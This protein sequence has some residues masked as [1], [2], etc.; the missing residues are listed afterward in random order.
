MCSV[1][2][3]YQ[4]RGKEGRKLC[5]EML[6]T[7]FPLKYSANS[8]SDYRPVLDLPTKVYFMAR[9]LLLAPLLVSARSAFFSMETL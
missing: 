8:Q 2:D 7:A 3:Q 1:T 9:L 6:Y 5:E 4:F